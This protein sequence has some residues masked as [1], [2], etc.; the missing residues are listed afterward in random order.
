MSSNKEVKTTHVGLQPNTSYIARVRTFDKLG[1]PSAWADAHK[2]TTPVLEGAYIPA[3]EGDHDAPTNLDIVGGYKSFLVDWD[4]DSAEDMKYGFGN[5]D[6]QVSDPNGTLVEDDDGQIFIAE[7]DPI[8]HFSDDDLPDYDPL[9]PGAAIVEFEVR[10]RVRDPYAV[11]GEDEAALA[12]GHL[13]AWSDT[14]TVSTDDSYTGDI[15][16]PQVLKHGQSLQS[17][18][19][20]A[21]TTVDMMELDTKGWRMEAPGKLGAGDVRL[22]GDL[23]V[24]RLSTALDPQTQSGIVIAS[25]ESDL[26]SQYPINRNTIY[27]GHPISPETDPIQS[28]ISSSYDE[29]EGVYAISMSALAEED[30]GYSISITSEGKIF[31][32]ANDVFIQGITLARPPMRML[33]GD[34]TTMIDATETTLSIDNSIFNNLDSEGN[35]FI[36]IDTASNIVTPQVE[37]WYHCEAVISYPSTVSEFFGY[38]GF[39][40]NP[41]VGGTNATHILESSGQHGGPGG[42]GTTHT[43]SG[44][45]FFVGDG[46]WGGDADEEPVHLRVKAFQ[47]SGGTLTAPD[48]PYIQR[49]EVKFASR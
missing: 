46:T 49:L 26:G 48:A 44:T 41:L 15:V 13:S 31:I 43:I 45:F 40:I 27:F 35:P 17:A 37:G 12:D 7:G 20:P 3:H 18:S 6:V 30:G 32:S 16:D 8:F 19:W 25:D 47:A 5:W 2:F 14:I 24:R 9:D 36:V 38:S 11:E 28:Q 10:V 42:F 39:D 33:T 34:P 21:L 29:G 1:N 22:R 4:A 23:V